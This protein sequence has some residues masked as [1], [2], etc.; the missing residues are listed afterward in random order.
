MKHRLTPPS[1]PWYNIP[2]KRRKERVKRAAFAIAILNALTASGLPVFGFLRY[3][4]AVF[5]S[6]ALDSALALLWIYGRMALLFTW[7]Q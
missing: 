2:T 3:G 7:Q 4:L 1:H 6:V 5:S